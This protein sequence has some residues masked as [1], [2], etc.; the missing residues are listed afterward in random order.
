[1]QKL[2]QKGRSAHAIQWTRQYLGKERLEFL[3]KFSL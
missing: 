1:M 2:A 3:P